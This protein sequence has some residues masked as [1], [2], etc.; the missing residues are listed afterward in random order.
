[1]P[2]GEAR[3]LGRLPWVGDAR[4]YRVSPPYVG[5]EHVVVSVAESFITGRDVCI[6]GADA[7][8]NPVNWTPLEGSGKH[9]KTHVQI[10]Q[11]L[12]YAV[13]D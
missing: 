1:M 9:R 4:V 3:F 8:G 10:L 11:E 6:L 2:L 13:F 7:E 5:F 12:G